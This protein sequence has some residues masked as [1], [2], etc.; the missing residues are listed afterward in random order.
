[1]ES[2]LLAGAACLTG[3]LLAYFGIKGL[4]A[5]IPRGQTADLFHGRIPE[6]TVIGLNPAVLLFAVGIA[7][8]TIL[9]C[10]LAP[11]LHAVRKNLEPRMFGSGKGVGG[12]FRHGKLRNGLVIAEVALSI[13]L[14]IAATLMIR[15]FFALTH[16]EVGFNPGR[17]FYAWVSTAAHGAN[18]T[19]AQKK[20][21]YEQVLQRVQRLPGV[22]NAT[23]SIGTPPLRGAGSEILI[24]GKQ[25]PPHSW[26]AVDLCSETYFQ[27]LGIRL[28]R[29]R[30]LSQPDI[31]SVGQV[32]VVNEAFVH[33]YF[34][35]ENVL[36]QK[37]KFAAFDELPEIPQEAYFEVIGVV[38]DFK[39]RGLL[40]PPRPEAFVP[41]SISG[42]RDR[43]ILAATAVDPKTL[44]AGVQREIWAVD[45][46]A[47]VIRS[48]SMQDFIG[49][50]EFTEPRFELMTTSAFAAI[51]L[52]LALVG[53]FSVM[54]YSVALRTHEIGVRMALG[55]Q[56]SNVVV[57]VL[58]QGLRLLSLGILIGTLAGL[59]LAHL[60]ASQISGVSVTDPLTFSGVLI[61]FLAV[62]V[63]AC[64]LAARRAAR[65]D[66]VIA[67][68]YE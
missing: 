42:F 22:I 5:I 31:D 57:M 41:Y 52:A 6:E 30:F 46:S 11:T 65:F 44:F 12:S 35:S 20:V 34:G 67:L 13:V 49:E 60:L 21:F 33:A 36:G 17:M 54:A 16:A 32:A 8:L 61:V 45:A 64:L 24:L 2:V 51:G 37:I 40:E 28:L 1:V 66:P 7:A 43:T 58:W 38:S 3:C 29:G 47:A 59:G 50:F 55:A 10:G 18:E 25:L 14:L 68:R 9:I 53:V 62:G 63:A 19:A 23:T 39:N 48:G 56:R 4:V 26:S 27:T 15:S